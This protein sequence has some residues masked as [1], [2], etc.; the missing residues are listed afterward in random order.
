MTLN[1]I[2]LPGQRDITVN[3][4]HQWDYGQ[5]LQ[6]ISS[7][8]PALIEVHFA[9]LG[10]RDAI[11]RPGA[12]IS[13][14]ATVTIP[15][16]C[17]EQTAPITAW[18]YEIEGTA[19]KTTKTVTLPVISRARPT[20]FEEVPEE[21][22]DK[23]TEA[24][25]EINALVGALAEGDVI[26]SKAVE[27]TSA[28]TAGYAT[29]AGWANEATKASEAVRANEATKAN[30]ANEADNAKKI[31]S[32]EIKRDS[33]GI[34]KIGERV[35]PQRLVRY[36][37][38]RVVGFDKSELYRSSVSMSGR[39]FEFVDSRGLITKIIIDPTNRIAEQVSWVGNIY[40]PITDTLVYLEIDPAVPQVIYAYVEYGEDYIIE[41]IYEVIE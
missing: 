16:V 23:Y 8:L 28:G 41:K 6:I 30:T 34:L 4:L 25:T 5:Q 24:I 31:N 27:A 35:I 19:G 10:A 1:A 14:Q 22:G 17:L 40:D 15:D 29:E 12:V 3:G 26:V 20:I 33:E 38:Q 11:V 13:G 39:T 7:D 21:V 2:F 32:L 9:H 36:A 37:I 18:I